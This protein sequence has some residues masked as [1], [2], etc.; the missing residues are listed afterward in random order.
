ML[1]VVSLSCILISLSVFIASLAYAYRQVKMTKASSV[2]PIQ[3]EETDHL[4]S[5]LQS[6]RQTRFGRRMRNP[7][8]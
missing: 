2:A 4:N 6:L 7:N 5:A 1:F 8:E 3:L